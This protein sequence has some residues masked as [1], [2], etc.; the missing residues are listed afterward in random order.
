MIMCAGLY[1]NFA[2]QQK[3]LHFVAHQEFAVKPSRDSVFLS[4]D[5]ANPETSEDTKKAI[6]SAIFCYKSL[7]V[8]K[9]GSNKY[10]VG[11]LT[12]ISPLMLALFSSNVKLRSDKFNQMQIEDSIPLQFTGAP[13]G[14]A[15]FLEFKR[16]FDT[17]LLA[18]LQNICEIWPRDRRKVLRTGLY[19]IILRAAL[20]LL[21]YEEGQSQRRAGDVGQFSLG[22]EKDDDWSAQEPRTVA[23]TWKPIGAV[24]PENQEG[25]EEVIVCAICGQPGHEYDDCTRNS[26]SSQTSENTIRTDQLAPWDPSAGTSDTAAVW[27]PNAID[28]EDQE[29]LELP[30]DMDYR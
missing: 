16:V 30:G 1:P 9:S 28:E 20:E 22:P 29:L 2:V 18:G 11:G 7:Y 15:V 14:A 17:A 19:D 10:Y 27:N 8:S 3:G 4:G 23:T 13:G 6:A 24:H 26:D 21:K 12:P 25:P 5:S